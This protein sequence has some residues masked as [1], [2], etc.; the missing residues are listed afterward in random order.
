MSQQTQG[1][2]SYSLI[3]F[4]ND[5][6]RSPEPVVKEFLGMGP[7]LVY[8]V[9][10]V[11]NLSLARNRCLTHATGDYVAIIDDDE[12]AD[13]RW[14]LSLYTTQPGFR[15]AVLNFHYDEYGSR[16]VPPDHPHE[17]V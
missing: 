13:S 4:D 6:C 11:Q 9:E 10:P 8:E 1:L 2:F 15:A 7:E 5:A 12:Y 14:L 16:Q 3:V 17:P